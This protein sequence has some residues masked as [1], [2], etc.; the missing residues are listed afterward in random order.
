MNGVNRIMLTGIRPAVHNLIQVAGYLEVSKCFPVQTHDK[1][2]Y[3]VISYDLATI[4][5]AGGMNY[6]LSYCH[7]STI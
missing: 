5:P 1:E 6:L 4:L 3:S 7:I 2:I